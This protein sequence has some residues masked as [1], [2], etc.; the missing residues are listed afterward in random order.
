MT[1]EVPVIAQSDVLV[2]GGT[3]HAVALALDLRQAGLAVHLATPYSYFGEDL[4]ATLDLQSPKDADYRRLMGTDA[5]LRPTEIKSR[6]DKA[7]I[8][9]GIA[10][11]FEMRPVRPMRD[12]A[13]A[14]CGALFADRGGFH[15]I[16]AKVVVDATWRRTFAREAGV[17]MRPFAPGRRSMT[18]FAIGGAPE[19]RPDVRVERLPEPVVFKDRTFPAFKLSMDWNF[20]GSTMFDFAAANAAF[21]KAAWSPEGV[22][23]PDLV[24]VDLGDD[25]DEGFVPSPDLPVFT[26]TRVSAKSVLALAA[27]RPAPEPAG[28]GETAVAHLFDVVRHDRS[29]RFKDRPTLPF[30]LNALPLVGDCDVFVAGGGT[31]GAPAAIGAAREG[32]RTVCA[33][34]LAQ[35]GGVMLTGRIGSYYYGNR[36]GF[37]H[38]ID[39]GITAMGPKPDFDTKK[40]GMN[41]VWKNEWFLEKATERGATM[42]F[43]ALTAAAAVD[44]RR[45]CGAVVATP[46][47]TGVLSAKFVVDA[48]GNS[49]FAAAAG[50]ETMCDLGREP[51]V[52]GAGLS[53]VDIG[54]NYTN[55]D[56]TFIL[57]GDIVD[58]TRA[59]VTARAKYVDG[60]DISTI[61]N[62]RERRRILGDLVLQPQDFF[63]N[64]IYADT[65]NRAW[66]NFDTHGYII[67]P[68]FM[69]KPTAHDAR[70]ANVPLR[71]LLPRGF[72]GIAVTG[73]GVSAHRDCMPLIRMQPDVQNQGYAAGR[74]AAMAIRGGCSIRAI[75]V[76]ALQKTLVAEDILPAAVLEETDVACTQIDDDEYHDIA[77][78]FVDTKAA[79]GDLRIRLAA[80]PDDVE[81]A[82][83]LAFLGDATG[84]DLLV[85]TIAAADWDDGWNYRGMG[86]FGPS[87][88]PLDAKIVALSTIGGD[89]DTTLAKLVTLT[90]EHAFSHIRAVSLALMRRPDPRAAAALERLLA[91]PGAAGHAIVTF[92]DALASNRPDWNDTTVRNAQLKELYLAKALAACDP[93]SKTARGIL[94]AYAE[95]M[96]GIYALFAGAGC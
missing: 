10:F 84:R 53:P 27:A 96:Q 63:A 79:L 15:A 57:D 37:T 20:N 77:R 43:D 18:M 38:E 80:N 52:Q 2:I 91:A 48:T 65:I 85:K 75:D 9:A 32:M 64:R 50:A 78:V 44:G 7:L 59:F 72:E 35:L 29:F 67:H 39:A 13:G 31:G 54:N 68:M 12:A 4:C 76:R 83:T 81:T 66:S 62:T 11:L 55:T 36:V 88:S 28:F 26:G 51:A 42:L 93:K 21:R 74:A 22:A 40:G 87:M 71:A 69:L 61:P 34:N 33:E 89:A 90:I 60:Y 14:L 17:P 5:T 8:D 47:G 6:L 25:V 45:A 41:V 23:Y 73:L 94:R 82:A 56:F 95:G 19:G 49:D 3:L 1:I 70:F 58:T 30:D 86:Q 24:A 46:F 92:Q 16:A